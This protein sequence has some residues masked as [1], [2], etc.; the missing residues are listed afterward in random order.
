MVSLYSIS[1]AQAM[2]TPPPPQRVARPSRLAALL[3]GVHQ[4]DHDAGAG[5]PHRVAETD[6]RA[7]DVGDLPVQ[8]QLLLAA[9]ILGGEGLVDLDQLEVG[10]LEPARPAGP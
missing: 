2:D 10:E 9:E 1:M 4:R 8:A 3:H 5:R 6:A 7:V